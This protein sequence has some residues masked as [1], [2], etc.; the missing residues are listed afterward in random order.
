[1]AE[2]HPV[3]RTFI[4]SAVVVSATTAF[5]ITPLLR[6]V[7]LDSFVFAGFA[8]GTGAALSWSAMRN[9]WG[10]AWEWPAGIV[11]IVGLLT[12]TYAVTQAMQAA[13]INDIRC[14]HV[15]EDM[16][17]PVPRRADLPELFQALGCRPQGTSDVQFPVLPKAAPS[18]APKAQHDVGPRAPVS[19]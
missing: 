11:L 12:G 14:I 13:T 17:M 19:H 6:Y 3:I 18:T 9:G 7:D 5:C 4:T 15:Q 16:L 8:V 1:L 2:E 10:R